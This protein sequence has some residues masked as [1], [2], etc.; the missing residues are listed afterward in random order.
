M[1]AENHVSEIQRTS[2]AVIEGAGGG[3]GPASSTAEQ[4]PTG[5]RSEVSRRLSE[6][7]NKNLKVDTSTFGDE[8]VISPERA[9]AL[10]GALE[11]FNSILRELVQETTASQPTGWWSRFW[12]RIKEHRA[13]LRGVFS[14]SIFGRQLTRDALVAEFA[15]LGP[16]LDRPFN[17]LYAET[18][19]LGL[20][21]LRA[22]RV[23]T[24][25]S[26]LEDVRF[27]TSP[28]ALNYVM[29]G[30]MRFV[31]IAGIVLYLLPFIV[32]TV[33]ENFK[34][35]LG[36]WAKVGLA[37]AFGCVGGVVSVLLRLSEFEATKGRSKQFLVVYGTTLPLVGGIFAVVIA[38]LLLSNIISFGT[39]GDRFSLFVVIGFLAG[40]SERF[41]RNILRVA[42][43]QFSPPSGRTAKS[44][45][46]RSSRTTAGGR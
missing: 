45:T 11:Q 3:A 4:Q 2:L 32:L 1:A 10:C 13:A 35:S 23:V 24:A 12:E 22:H 8:L 31:Y 19:L 6:R 29:R 40:F 7:S 38:S 42:E 25:Q 46:S 27:A 28:I 41:T 16:V 43:G 9:A 20:L 15:S 37:A 17:I 36:D 34:V 44:Q 21:A 14:A 18:A 30:V 5:T 26:I 39:S 33:F